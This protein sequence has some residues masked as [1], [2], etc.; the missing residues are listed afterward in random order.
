MP[1]IPG[2]APNDPEVQASLI[3]D[4]RIEI[5]RAMG[6]HLGRLQSATW[7][8]PGDFSLEAD[9]IGP[10]S[11]PYPQWFV[12]RMRRSLGQCLAATAESDTSAQHAEGS[13]A[14]AGLH[15]RRQLGV[16]G[17]RFVG[18]DFLL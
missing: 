5:A 1:R 2:V 12:A 15:R 8:H 3:R 11:G 9:G 6:E 4:D 10:L 16:A 7:E 14:G 17:A 13:R 18:H